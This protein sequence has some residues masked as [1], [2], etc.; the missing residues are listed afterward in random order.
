MSAGG[1][2]SLGVD[3]RLE[4]MLLFSMYMNGCMRA[5]LWVI[6]IYV[7]YFNFFCLVTEAVG[8]PGAVPNS[9]TLNLCCIYHL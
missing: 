7:F 5:L 3:N 1:E 4:L 8:V 6:F 9:I 2:T